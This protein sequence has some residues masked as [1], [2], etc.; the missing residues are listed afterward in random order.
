MKKIIAVLIFV[1]IFTA[2]VKASQG[3]KEIK[4]LVNKLDDYQKVNAKLLKKIANIGSPAIPYLLPKIENKNSLT[5]HLAA[6]VFSLMKDPAALPILANIY[7]KNRSESSFN[8]LSIVMRKRKDLCVY[9]DTVAID[10]D[11]LI[12][13]QNLLSW[14]VRKDSLLVGENIRVYDHEYNFKNDSVIVIAEQDVFKK[15]SFSLPDKKIF[16]F[17]ENERL[18]WADKNGKYYYLS[19]NVCIFPL[20]YNDIN[21]DS[22][23]LTDNKGNEA[24]AIVGI[25]IIPQGDRSFK[26]V[27]LTGSG[28]SSLWVKKNGKWHSEKIF[29]SWI[30]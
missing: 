14:V 3:D 11:R 7:L 13:C 30:S 4:R 24:I 2:L 21:E 29:E 5:Y 8:A 6:E 25:S 9:L 20:S 17:N 22:F 23:G 27:W 1:V 26:G 12:L 15:Y 16:I 18:D 28:I 10:E 19:F